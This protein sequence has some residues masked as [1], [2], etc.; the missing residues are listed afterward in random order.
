MIS[1]ILGSRNFF[2]PSCCPHLGIKAVLQG[3]GPVSGRGQDQRSPGRPRLRRGQHPGRE[4]AVPRGRASLGAQEPALGP[5]ALASQLSRGCCPC[6]LSG[7]AADPPL[8]FSPAGRAV[9]A[10]RPHPHPS[11]RHTGNRL[12]PSLLKEERLLPGGCLISGTDTFSPVLRQPCRDGS[13][14]VSHMGNQ[15]R[16]RRVIQLEIEH[17]Y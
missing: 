9:N 7:P 13:C 12:E 1:I 17:S 3:A 11:G 14:P 15:A 2:L 10:T 8:L 6:L 4:G 16:L 5:R